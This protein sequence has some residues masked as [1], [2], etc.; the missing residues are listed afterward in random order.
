MTLAFGN[1]SNYNV[2]GCF[3][4]LVH[5]E[6]KSI[7]VCALMPDLHQ[8]PEINELDSRKDYGVFNLY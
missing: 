5:V 1:L 2:S 7:D 6:H 4:G 3:V 8:T